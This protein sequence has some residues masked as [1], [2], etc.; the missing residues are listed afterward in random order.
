[1]SIGSFKQ[2]SNKI[3]VADPL[4]TTLNGKKNSYSTMIIAKNVLKGTWHM[5]QHDEETEGISYILH[6][7]Y[8][9]KYKKFR[10]VDKWQQYDDSVTLWSRMFG[11]FDKT[12]FRNDDIVGNKKISKFIKTNEPG[13]KWYNYCDYH[14]WKGSCTDSAMP[15]GCTM[16]MTKEDF[17]PADDYGCYYLKNDNGKIYG[18]A[19]AWFN[20]DTETETD[21]YV[22][23][24][25]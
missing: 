8:A 6:D 2:T 17:L 20:E 4:D 23:S 1:M 16:T 19:V 15:H 14:Y 21:S 5:F 25:E 9:K 22:D 18:L 7:T 13:D 11:F 24:D 10:S 12:F 3:I